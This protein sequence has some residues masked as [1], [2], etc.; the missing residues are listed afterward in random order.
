MRENNRDEVTSESIAAALSAFT[1]VAASVDRDVLM[2]QAG[3]QAAVA[4]RSRSRQA[5]VQPGTVEGPDDPLLDH[6]GRP[7]SQARSRFRKLWRV[8]RRENE[9]S[10]LRLWQATTAVMTAACLALASML[11]H[12][13]LSPTEPPLA[14][15]APRV[16][17]DTRRPLA[18]PLDQPPEAEEPRPESFE[19]TV[20]QRG[21]RLLVHG[22]PA[23]NYLALRAAMLQRGVDRWSDD[24]RTSADE[25]LSG[26]PSKVTTVRGL[27][28]ELLPAEPAR[29]PLPGNASAEEKESIV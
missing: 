27:L 22:D 2:Y 7:T 29:D 20:S 9:T 23:K 28:E 12:T 8:R 15:V 16:S 19:P 10:S 14:N 5:L 6:S 21:T 18:E 4:E 11:S 17:D 13:P 25:P 1:P 3:F 24:A 26:R